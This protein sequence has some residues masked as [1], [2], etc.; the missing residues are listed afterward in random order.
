VVVLS[1]RAGD[2][3]LAEQQ[4]KH[5]SSTLMCPYAKWFPIQAHTFFPAFT[6]IALLAPQPSPK[7]R[8][9]GD[10]AHGAHGCSRGGLVDKVLIAVM[11]GMRPLVHSDEVYLHMRCKSVD[12]SQKISSCSSVIGGLHTVSCMQPCQGRRRSS[13]ISDVGH[14]SQVYCSCH[15]ASRFC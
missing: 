4:I 2:V 3:A 14:A 9:V 13:S 5:A 11:G 10:P 12:T 7:V 8:A 6:A 15:C 1:P